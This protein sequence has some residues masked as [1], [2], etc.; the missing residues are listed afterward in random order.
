MKA[1]VR[2]AYPSSNQNSD[3]AS[4]SGWLRSS[5][6]TAFAWHRNISR[7]SATPGVRNPSG[8]AETDRG[9]P[10]GLQLAVTSVICSRVPRGSCFQV[11]KSTGTQNK[12]FLFQ[13]SQRH[14]DSP[15]PEGAVWRTGDQCSAEEAATRMVKRQRPHCRYFFAAPLH[16]ARGRPPA[17]GFRM[18]LCLREILL[19]NENDVSVRS[20]TAPSM[21][22]TNRFSTAPNTRMSRYNLGTQRPRDGS[23]R[24]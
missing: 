8:S 3:A 20:P 14:P 7:K 5:G 11:R 12:K 19:R 16:R 23:G 4:A 1:K 21:A 10:S 22:K 15:G 2:F 17:E 24:A 18:D 9:L 13:Y 6:S